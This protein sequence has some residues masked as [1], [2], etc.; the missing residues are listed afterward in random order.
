MFDQLTARLTEAIQRVTGRGRITEDNVRDTVRTIRMALLEADVALPVAKAFVDRVRD[1]A[2]G[3]EVARSLNPGQ[4]FVKIVHD[5]LVTVLGG[6][7]SPLA[8]R[9]QPAVIMLVGLQGA[10]KTTTA[11]KLRAHLTRTRRGSAARQHRRLPA[12]GPRTVREAC[13]GSRRQAF[14][15]HEQRRLRRLRPKRWPLRGAEVNAG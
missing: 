6:E 7:A 12:R 5:E 14:P 4:T 10:G 2:L 15:T 13:G 11:A 8:P 3:E 9:G 1:R